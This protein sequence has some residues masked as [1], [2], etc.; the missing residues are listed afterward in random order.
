VLRG[1]GENYLDIDGEIV[2]TNERQLAKMAANN[3]QQSQK[4]EGTFEYPNI[5]PTFGAQ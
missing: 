5:Y 3:R 1:R 4:K 2:K